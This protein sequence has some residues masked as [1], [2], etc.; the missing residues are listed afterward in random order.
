MGKTKQP[1][2]VAPSPVIPQN[3]EYLN[4]YDDITSNYDDGSQKIIRRFYFY[5]TDHGNIV[6]AEGLRMKIPAPAIGGVTVTEK[7]SP[8]L[9]QRI[10]GQ[11]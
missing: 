4:C 1:K 2:E 8:S 10:T 6:T 5:D 3:C 9:W 7:K 11:A